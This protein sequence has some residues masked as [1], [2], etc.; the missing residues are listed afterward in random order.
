MNFFKLLATGAM[1]AILAACTTGQHPLTD[2]ANALTTSTVGKNAQQTF[3]STGG[4]LSFEDEI[5]YHLFQRSFYDSNGDNHGDL[6]GITKKLDYLQELGVTSIL[7]TPLYDSPFYHNYF[8]DDFEKIDPRYGSLADYLK[9]VEEVHRRGMKIYMDMEVHYVAENHI[10]FK[11]SLHN[12]DS[13]YSD[14]ILYN[15]PNNSKPESAIFFLEEMYSYT[16]DK[17]KLATINLESDKVKAYLNNLFAYWVD[18]N[19]DGDFSDGVDGFRIDHMMDDLDLKGQLTNLFTDLWAPIFADIKRINPNLVIIA[20]QADWGYGE[21]FWTKGNVDAVFGFPI[22]KA[23]VDFDKAALGTAIKTTQQKQP[24]GKFN[25]LFIENHDTHRFASVVDNDPGKL[26]VAAA[27]NM[28][29]PGVPSLYYGQEIGMQGKKQQYNTS[30]ANDIPVR[31][32]FNWKT[33][34]NY[35]GM[36]FWYRG[37]GPWWADSAVK[38][39]RT[40]SLEQQAAD[41]QS[42][43]NF[44]RKLIALRKQ[45]DALRSGDIRILNREHASVLSFIRSDGDAAYLISINF[46]DQPARTNLAVADLGTVG[47][48]QL[49]NLKSE[50][51]STL[52]VNGGRLSYDLSP[53][54]VYLTKLR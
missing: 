23:L 30:D 39:D 18:P 4:R 29:L 45:K 36:A 27:A 15:G 13:R 37:N 48:L 11:D 44:Y 14:Y 35:D 26:R 54:G 40:R 6:N 3:A 19:G 46:G 9:L 12:P 32:A 2:G 28:L 38:D 24:A 53:Y 47:G 10:W 21:E 49:R 5:V 31:E 33:D 17:Y 42:L 8:A 34:K 20:E 52:S 16:G 7:L 22:M 25:L 43:W 50:A 1:V 41:P 51:S